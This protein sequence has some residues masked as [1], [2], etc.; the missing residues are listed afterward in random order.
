M[1]KPRPLRWRHTFSEVPPRVEYALTEKGLDG[2]MVSVAGQLELRYVPFADLIDPKTLNT[3]VRF[4]ERGSEVEAT[5]TDDSP[6]LFKGN[7]SGSVESFGLPRSKNQQRASPLTLNCG[8]GLSTVTGLAA[9]TV[10]ANV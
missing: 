9:L 2:H 5:A 1:A 7:F 4:I 10:Q 6:A 8:P 3:E